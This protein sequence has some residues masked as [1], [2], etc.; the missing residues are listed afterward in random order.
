MV[1]F[2]LEVIGIE[3]IPEVHEGDSIPALI[4]DACQKDHVSLTAG[5]VL[6]VAHK[7]VSKAEGRI[8][9]LAG[10]TPS[11]FARTIAQQT[12]KDPRSIE[13]ILA[14][15]RRIV[16]MARGILIVET[17][18]GFICANGGVDSSNVGPGVVALLPKDPDASAENIRRELEKVTGVQLAVII[19]D[20]FGRPWRTGSVDVA[21]GVA[22]LEPLIDDRGQKDKSG[23]EM[24]ASLIAVADELAGAG[25]LVLGKTR[26]IPVAVIRGFSSRG[27][28][29]KGGQLI[30]APEVDIFR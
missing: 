25:E 14:E 7:I 3:N 24:K 28:Q 16:R 12:G 15:S 11:P 9:D 19:S 13:V 27:T 23:Y 20:S 1:S 21:I 5:D 4:V 18:Q 10:V 8:V 26:Q 29:G 17:H 2:R 30:R 22:G 6:I